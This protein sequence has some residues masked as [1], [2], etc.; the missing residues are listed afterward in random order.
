MNSKQYQQYQEAV[1]HNLEGLE[2]VSTG[3]CSGCYDCNLTTRFAIFV[4]DELRDKV[5]VELVHD[6]EDEALQEIEAAKA[7]P[8]L[9]EIDLSG[10]TV[11][12]L[13]P[14][15]HERELAEEPSFSWSSCDCCGST[16]GGDRHP[17]HGY[18][19]DDN[20]IHLN[21]CADCFYYLNYG[22]LDDVSML[23]IEATN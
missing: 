9:A 16:L 6:S 2:F 4:P 14:T 7:D 18:D 12:T 15:D 8:D 19:K 5:C 3:A 20:L 13:E 22:Q 21:V 11:E 23:E 10:L 17:A 1:K